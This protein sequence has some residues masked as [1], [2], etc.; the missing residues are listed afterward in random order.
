MSARSH[1]DCA[2]SRQRGAVRHRSG[3]RRSRVTAARRRAHRP[4]RRRHARL[5]G[6]RFDGVDRARRRRRGHRA[7]Q[8]RDRGRG[9][10]SAPR[11]HR[12]CS[13]ERAARSTSLLVALLVLNAGRVGLAIGAY[14]TRAIRATAAHLPLELAAMSLA[15]GAY[16]QACRQPLT[17]RALAVVAAASALLLVAAATLETYAS[18][19]APR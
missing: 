12:D 6:L 17:A 5:L 15:G 19:G 11:S 4:R 2:R 10:G 7:A 14:G 13:R 16:M 9:A 8:R 1:P 18:P 3:R